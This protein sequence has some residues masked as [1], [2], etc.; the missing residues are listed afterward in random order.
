MPPAVVALRAMIVGNKTPKDLEVPDTNQKFIE[1]LMIR[2]G[3]GLN[4]LEKCNAW[5]ESINK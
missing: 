4:Y 2:K 1:T 5:K 3:E